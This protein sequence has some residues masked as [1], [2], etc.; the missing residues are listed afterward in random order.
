MLVLFADAFEELRR[1]YVVILN[2]LPARGCF[3]DFDALPEY[4][5]KTVRTIQ[6]VLNIENGEPSGIRMKFWLRA[7]ARRMRGQALK[8]RV[9]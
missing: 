4:A 1:R 5:G 9:R 8:A 2:D 7:R 3:E 6:V